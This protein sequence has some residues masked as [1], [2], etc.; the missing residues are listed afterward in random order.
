MLGAVTTAAGREVQEGI[1]HGKN[2]YL[3]QSVRRV[4]LVGPWVVMTCV[5]VSGC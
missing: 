2:E 3:K 5:A 4:M 1:V